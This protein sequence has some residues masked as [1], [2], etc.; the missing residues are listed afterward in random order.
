MSLWFKSFQLWEIK[1]YFSV[2]ISCIGQISI[3]KST[4]G[5]GIWNK[6]HII[7][8]LQQTALTNSVES[9]SFLSLS[10]KKK[11]FQNLTQQISILTSFN[12][13]NL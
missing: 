2:L 11:I 12:H 8:S 4:I 9:S 6:L 1:C 7:T 10:F 13:C 3:V 5:T